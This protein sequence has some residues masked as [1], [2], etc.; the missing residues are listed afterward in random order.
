MRNLYLSEVDQLARLLLA[1][2]EVKLA[3]RV[4][5]AAADW[6]HVCSITPN[7]PAPTVVPFTP[8]AGEARA[9]D[10]ALSTLRRRRV[11]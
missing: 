10:Q 5:H 7:K 1:D 3:H 6:E 4:R 8:T 2:G 9:L 11:A